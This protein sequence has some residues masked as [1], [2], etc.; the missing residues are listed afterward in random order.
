MKKIILLTLLAAVM[1][2]GSSA[3]TAPAKKTDWEKDGLKGKVKSI[4]E[5]TYEAVEKFGKLT[6]GEIF[7]DESGCFVYQRKY[8]TKGNK[9]EENRYYSNGSLDDKYTYKYDDKGNLTEE[10]RYKSNGSLDWKKTYKYDGK[11]NRTELNIYDSDG[12]LDR[13]YT[14]KYD[15]KGNLIEENYYNSNGSLSWKYTYKYDGK[16]NNIEYN[17]YED[18]SLD[19]KKTYKYDDKGNCIEMTE[20]NSDGSLK[21]K[22]TYKVAVQDDEVKKNIHKLLDGIFSSNKTYKYDDKG[23]WIEEIS[24]DEIYYDTDTPIITERTIEYYE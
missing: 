14:Y 17:V 10:N 3:Q 1:T 6:K 7:C 9:I 4:R 21:K 15:D 5:I 8:D 19:S 20:Y 22:D 18:G 13:E 16:G 11:G 24:Y 12:S 23:N 2:T